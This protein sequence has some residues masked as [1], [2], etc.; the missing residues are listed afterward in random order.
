MCWIARLFLLQR[1]K[2]SMSG[3]VWD[4]N[5]IK[6]WP[7]IKFFFLQG[8][9]L[10]EIH[11]ILTETLGEHAPSYAT[12]K[13]WVAQFKHGDF[14]T[15]DVSRP[16]RPKTVT[17]PEIIDHIH[18]LIL[19]VRRISAKSIVEQ[20]GISHERVGSIIHEDLDMR[21]LSAKWVLKCLNVD[22]KPQQCQSSEQLP[23]F[24]QGDPN[25]FLS[26]LVTRDE[27]WLYHYDLETKW[28]STEWRHS[29]S[30]HSKNFRVQK[31]AAK[32]LASIFGIKTASSS[33]IIFQR[34]KLSWWSIIHFCW[35][36]WRTF[37]RKNATGRSSRGL[38]LARQCPGSP[39]TCNPEE[40]GLPE[41]QK[42]WSPTLF[43]G[44]G[45]VRLPPVPWTEK[46]NW[47]VTIFHP[48]QR[49]SQLRRPG[50][51]ENLLIFFWGACKS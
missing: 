18:K 14:S 9:V 12:V 21:E 5:D 25:D 22:Q 13:N 1:L 31:S 23:E 4:F 40:T 10:K 29:G 26:R 42:S 28:Q 43:S 49:S 27:T 7:V 2:G 35:C 6:T 15:C 48:T 36:N 8:K 20:L 46:N 32:V 19:E 39:G 34:A 24:F 3:N 45:P 17:T 44:S 16:G 47:K 11:A 30:P 51:P 38:V 41:L 37:W 50:W 33:L